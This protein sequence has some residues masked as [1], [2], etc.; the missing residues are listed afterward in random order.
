MQLLQAPMTPPLD[1]AAHRRENTISES[2]RNFG[3]PFPSPSI[4]EG[5]L[6]GVADG[7]N[8][9]T[10][11]REALK[12]ARMSAERSR[13]A[14]IA[15]HANANL[16]EGSRHVQAAAIAAQVIALALPMLDRARS[17]L[18]NALTA[19]REKVKGPPR[20]QS[21]SGHMQAAEL[22]A[23]LA[24][25]PATERLSTI[26]KSLAE[27]DDSLAS[28][29]IHA[30]RFLTGLSE[31]DQAHV[32]RQW[33]VRRQPEALKRIEVLEKDLEH[34]ERAGSLLLA[35]QFKCSDPLILDSA[36]K[37]AERHAAAVKAAVAP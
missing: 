2:G 22:R 34:L 13:V 36:R 20:D 8:V 31:I 28:S 7:D 11:A 21:I 32:A 24:S 9:R 23:L 33:A 18:E 10:L 4:S 15:I 17:N 37:N 35:F 26:A 5:A 1:L 3:I 25:L 27:D 6:G 12:G 30:S 16:T 29:A 14:A 19:L